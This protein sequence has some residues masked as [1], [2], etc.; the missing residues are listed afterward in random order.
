MGQAKVQAE[1]SVDLP[2]STQ[3]PT[4]ELWIAAGLWRIAST[5]SG[6][7]GDG[8]GGCEDQALSE[9]HRQ[10]EDLLHVCVSA[11]GLHEKS[12]A[13]TKG[14]GENWVEGG[15]GTLEPI[16]RIPLP[17]TMGSGVCL[18]TLPAGGLRGRK[19]GEGAGVPQHT[20][21]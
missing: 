2:C 17:S 6:K 11:Y 10:S 8:A 20:Y 3:P 1:P 15:E 18:L 12:T 4:K 14:G 13:S 21:L 7:G 19:G 9:M 5:R 16:F